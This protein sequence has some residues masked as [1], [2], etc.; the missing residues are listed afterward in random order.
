[1]LLKPSDRSPSKTT[2]TTLFQSLR[3]DEEASQALQ[4]RLLELVGGDEGKA[5]EWVAKA[6]FADYGHSED[7]YWWKAI[8][9]CQTAKDQGWGDG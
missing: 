3:N 5:E 8:Q 4:R 9:A 6:R 7:Y 2:T 1:M